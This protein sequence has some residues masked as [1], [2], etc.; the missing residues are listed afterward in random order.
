M[1]R[2]RRLWLAI[3]LTV[4]L[5]LGRWVRATVTGLVVE[6]GEAEAAGTLRDRLASALGDRSLVLGYWLA[7]RGA[8]VD[9]RGREVE[10]PDEDGDSS[11]HRRESLSAESPIT[12]TA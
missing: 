10:L 12:V 3:G 5:V 2:G 9:D 1:R 6:L 7:D 8:Y 11:P 4:D